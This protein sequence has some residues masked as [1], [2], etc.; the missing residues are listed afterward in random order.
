LIVG[1]SFQILDIHLALQKG[2]LSLD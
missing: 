2:I 1:L